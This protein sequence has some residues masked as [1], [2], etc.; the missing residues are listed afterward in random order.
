MTA[1]K[2]LAAS[3]LM[4]SLLG[5]AARA[6]PML[7]NGGS[8]SPYWNLWLS[9]S[10]AS[11]NR[12][13]F[14]N[15]LASNSSASSALSSYQPAST[16][17][18]GSST[19]SSSSGATADAY[20][21]FGNGPYPESSALTTGGAQPWYTSPTVEKFYGGQ[22][23]NAQQQAAFENTVLQDVQTTFKLSG[24]LNPNLTIDPSVSANHTLSVVSNTSNGSNPNAIGI[25]DVGRNGFSFIDKLTGAQSLNDLEWA[26]AHNVAHELMHAFGVAAHD[27]KTGQYLDSATATWSLLTNPNT[28]FSQAAID[29]IRSRNF[30]PSN[31]NSASLGAEQIDGDLEIVP[32]PVPEPTTLVMWGMLLSLFVGVRHRLTHQAV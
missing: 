6:E 21:N 4:A 29:D 5:T 28:T 16:S 17:S 25:T 26:V 14:L 32:S 20:I 15:S 8:I 18:T 30:D 2:T 22:Q 27:D 10:S 19:T 9:L 13:S 23:P 12:S 31:T 24:G 3:V 7:D 11:A 1:V